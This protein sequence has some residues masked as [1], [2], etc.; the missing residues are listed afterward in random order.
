MLQYVSGN[1]DNSTVITIVQDPKMNNDL[2][3]I[4]L[5]RM[6]KTV[7]LDLHQY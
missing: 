5:L 4:I 3:N 6:A 1:E 2:M 7:L